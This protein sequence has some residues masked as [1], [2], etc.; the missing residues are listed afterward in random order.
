MS[1][2]Y[3]HPDNETHFEKFCLAFLKRHWGNPNLELYAHRG[4]KQHGVDIVDPT[5]RKPFQAAQCKHYNPLE[6]LPPEDI[7]AEV[8]KALGFPKRLEH[9]AILTTAKI[10]GQAQNAVI[11]LNEQHR[12]AGLFLVE[13]FSW[14]KLQ[15]LLDDY[16]GLETHLTALTNAHLIQFNDGI[17]RV[18][19]RLDSIEAV[20]TRSDNDH[21]IDR[22][23][24]YFDSHN[25]PVALAQLGQIRKHRWESLQPEQRYR[26]QTG[27]ANVHL[28]QGEDREAGKLLVTG[29]A[30]LPD[31]E[32]ARINEVIGYEMLGEKEKARQLASDL[33]S[34]YPLSSKLLACWIRTAEPSVVLADLLPHLEPTVADDAE[35]NLAMALHAMAAADYE[36]AE[37]Y[38]RRA[39]QATT[40]WVGPY[41]LLGH[42]ILQGQVI[43]SRTTYWMDRPRCDPARLQDSVAA[44]DKALAMARSQSVTHLVVE[45]LVYRASAKFL[46]GQDDEADDD[47]AE[48]HRTAPDHPGVLL[49]Y[50][51]HLHHRK[52]PHQAIRLL[53]RLIQLTGAIEAKHHLVAIL[54]ERDETGDQREA[55]G[56]LRQLVVPKE[57]RPTN[58]LGLID[59]REVAL[60]FHD[61]LHGLADGL[62]AARQYDQL[63]EIISA[64]SPSDYPETALATTWSKL[65]FARGNRDESLRLLSIALPLVDESTSRVELRSLAIHL[66]VMERHS[67]ALPL[68]ERLNRPGEFT[69]DLRHL[70][71]CAE[72]LDRPD[73]V[74]SVCKDLRNSGVE[75]PWLIQKE[76]DVLLT[77]DVEQAI[78]LLKDDLVKHPDRSE[79]RLRLTQIGLQLDRHDL[80]D[81][82]PESLPVVEIVTAAGGAITVE[83]LK[84][85]GYPNEALDY[86][87]RLYRRYRDE[88]M[89]NMALFS[90]VFAFG[91]HS[92]EIPDFSEA[93]CGCAVGY[94]ELTG[95]EG[96]F[97]I[98]DAVD[99]NR[100]FGEF[101]PADS[102]S[103]A[104]LGKR[105]G[106]EFELTTIFGHPRTAT[107][108]ELRSKF[109]Y[110]AWQ[111]AHTWP[112]RFRDY[113]WL[114]S[115]QVI[116][117]DAVTGEEKPDLSAFEAIADQAE[118][119]RKNA[120]KTYRESHI[121]IHVFANN[122]GA[123]DFEA[124]FHAAFRPDLEVRACLDPA[125]EYAAVAGAMQ[126]G[127]D[128]VID[129][130]AL[131]TLAICGEERILERRPNKLLVSLNTVLHL[132]LIL[133]ELAPRGRCVGRFVKG[134]RGYGIVPNDDELTEGQGRL[135]KEFVDL[136]LSKTT[137]VPCHDL[138]YI[139]PDKRNT[140]STVFG[141]HALE[142]I[143]IAAQ[144]GRILWTDDSALAAIARSEF[145]TRCI[146]TQAAT[147]HGATLG[148]FP[149]EDLY[150]LT[151]KLI[152][153]RYAAVVFNERVVNRAASLAEWNPNYWP[154][155]QMLDQFSNPGIAIGEA[156]RLALSLIEALYRE[157]IFPPLRQ[158][159]LVALAERLMKR[160]DGTAFV[161]ALVRLLPKVFGL[162]VIHLQ[163]AT[164]VLK[165][166]L[167][168]AERRLIIAKW[169]I[170]ELPDSAS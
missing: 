163:E 33:R 77:I 126:A 154:F 32:R 86:A 146:W 36:N 56:L 20:A 76:L 103:K 91:T 152:G 73:V 113:P 26:V 117:R 87:Y 121:P 9:Y 64:L 118:E 110:R 148:Y 84:A 153:C 63:E 132:Q 128:L 67:D 131:A 116:R 16:P 17:E 105:V 82:T 74:L 92:P 65:H 94:V 165:A 68:W 72:R 66:M 88:P 59:E 90:A 127:H 40:T 89:A 25:Y 47:F 158:R 160:V 38:A 85:V 125:A 157:T 81:C 120:E 101:A 162:N 96:W 10:S 115:Y 143:V 145:G 57:S 144:P 130:T 98:E 119:R 122:L 3:P 31:S 123:N 52:D 1:F 114:G 37:L 4:E 71:R 93:E 80:I 23:L 34:V 39:T 136:V 29:R 53:R 99:P 44:L 60:M 50:A 142:S 12:E 139:D 30:I 61:A 150:T 167:A 22:A 19:A 18:G 5:S 11:S 45:T 54:F 2:R 141:Q 102:L 106:E 109:A 137:V 124:M 112:L 62:I 108:R 135:R 97:I 24:S 7:R 100:S 169:P 166:W 6:T 111:I 134:L 140:L 27:L 46:L 156:G 129:I 138:I 104:A 79:L 43:A 51:Q 149:M 21:E 107:I 49:R 69:N 161:Q 13:L 147:E 70:I 164:D 58:T 28:A 170:I 42:A 14:D 83:V 133:G 151:A 78:A 95:E 35:V 159:V 15:D 55:I 168:D 75:D 41:V 8:T 48:A 155:A